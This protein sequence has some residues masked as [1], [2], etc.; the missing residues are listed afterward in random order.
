MKRTLSLLLSLSVAGLLYAQYIDKPIGHPVSV[1]Y[2]LPEGLKGT[3][4]VKKLVV[5]YN[6]IAYL[7]GPSGL[8]RVYDEEVVKDGFYLSLAD[9][10]PTDICVQERTGYLYYLYPDQYLSNASAGTIYAD[11]P[12]VYDRICVNQHEEILVYKSGAG[13][14]Y[15]GGQL[16]QQVSM[17]SGVRDV[18]ADN[19]RFYA[20]A[21]Q[22]IFLLAG[23]DWQ[24]FYEAKNLTSL[25][26]ENAWILAGSE[27]G[28]LT[29]SSE[30]KAFGVPNTKVPVPAVNKLALNDGDLWAI[31]DEGAFHEDGAHYRYYA[32]QRWLDN[33][34]LIDIGFDRTGDVYLLSSTGLNK[35]QYQPMTLAQK[36]A[37]FEDQ[38]RKNHL[39]YDFVSSLSRHHGDASRSP[40]VH[41]NDNDGLWTSFYV[42]SQALRY[43]V[44]GEEEA[45]RFAWESFGAFERLLT[46]NPLK[47]FP[48]RTFERTGYKVSDKDRWRANSPDAGWEWKG[49]T[50]SDEFVAYILVAAM[51]E[52][53]VAETEEERKRVADFIDAILMHIIDND[54]YFIDDD[55]Q[56]T[57]WG[58]WHPEFV[59]AYAETVYDR[60]LN[61]ILIIAG[62]QQGYALTGKEIYRKELERVFHEFGYL[63]NL[64]VPMGDIKPTMHRYGPH[65]MGME[66]NHSD[67][68]MA[69]LTYWVLHRYALNDRLKAKYEWVIRDHWEIEKPEKNALWNL[70]AKATSGDIDY[71]GTLWHLEEFPLDLKNY[72][73]KNSHRQDLTYLPENFR[74]QTTTRLIPPN[75]QPMHR[76]NANPFRLDSGRHNEQL[77]GDEYLFPYWL[78]RY[79]KI[80]MP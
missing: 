7:L 50:S 24:A 59:N 41:D 66:W 8:Y 2:N 52:E 14:I 46:V 35:I 10:V 33:D 1:K 44:T 36:A 17:P 63:K 57:T 29:I 48:S 38:I 9:K 79:L 68:E 16:Q 60:K 23:E 65:I 30:G 32:S 6:G 42:S 45:A 49:T 54:Y 58:R 76:H 56:P 12:Q 13:A 53:F 70:I 28:I 26:F 80:V 5:D 43:A 25:A 69:F 40:F 11:L 72:P 47:G 51:M 77:A 4:A 37:T 75:E 55:G 71:K 64:D 22:G 74:G 31:T 67:D 73:I 61:S 19:G 18:Y 27:D 62:L 15:Q 39:R 34:A 3:D 20:L 78:A 21:E